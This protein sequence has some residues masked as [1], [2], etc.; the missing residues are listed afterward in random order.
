MQYREKLLHMKFDGILNFM[1]DIG[2]EEI[3]T[4]IKYFAY[5]EGKFPLEEAANEINFTLNFGKVMGELAL[6]NE[7]LK[8][9]DYEFEVFEVKLPKFQKSSR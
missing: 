5:L 9:P 1:G 8:F 6:P 2:R 4:N 3:F 7:L